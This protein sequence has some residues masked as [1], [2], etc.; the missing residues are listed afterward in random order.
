VT[1]FQLGLYVGANWPAAT[2]KQPSTS[3]T[4]LAGVY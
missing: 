3:Q 4:D 1:E 2:F